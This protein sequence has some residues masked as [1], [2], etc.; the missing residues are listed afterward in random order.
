[1]YETSLGGGKT[2]LMLGTDN[3]L[4]EYLKGQKKP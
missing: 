2:K 3:S 4:F 1:L